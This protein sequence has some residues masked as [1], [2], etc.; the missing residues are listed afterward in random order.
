M[1]FGELRTGPTFPAS[2]PSRRLKHQVFLK[3]FFLIKR[4]IKD[5]AILGL[6]SKRV[7][8]WAFSADTVLF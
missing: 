6:G 1:N 5:A 4:E 7:W 2:E 8:G 3:I